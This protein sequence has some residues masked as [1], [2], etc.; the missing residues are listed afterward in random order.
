MLDKV[1]E[2]VKARIAKIIADIKKKRRERR[3]T[4]MSPDL[5]CTVCK[6]P[7][8]RDEFI[9]LVGKN[10]LLPALYSGSLAR[11]YG[12]LLGTKKYCESCFN[13]EFKK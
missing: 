10:K 11:S 5:F 2:F 13:K 9:A 12:W 3:L 8:R 4:K 7:I 1:K 6:Q